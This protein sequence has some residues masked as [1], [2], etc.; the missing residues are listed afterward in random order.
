MSNRIKVLHDVETVVELLKGA[1]TTYKA[2][3]LT[4]AL[5]AGKTYLVQQWMRA[6]EVQDKVT[7]PT[8]SLVNIYQKDNLKIY[9]MDMY[10]LKSVEEAMGIGF[11]E[12]IDEPEGICIIEWPGLVM[13]MID[14]DYVKIDINVDEGERTYAITYSEMS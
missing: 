2:V 13:P 3:L 6:I 8:F 9:H 11:M 12:M 7:S 1:M 4:G 10:R 5:G 14:H